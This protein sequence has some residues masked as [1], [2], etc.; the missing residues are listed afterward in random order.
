MPVGVLGVTV[1]PVFV[2]RPPAAP[3]DTPVEPVGPTPPEHAVVVDVDPRLPALVDEPTEPVAPIHGPPTTLEP[4][5]VESVDELEP[6][7]P[8]A[9]PDP[10]GRPVSPV[11]GAVTLDG[12]PVALPPIP[13]VFAVDPPPIEPPPVP[14]PAPA[15]PL[16]PCANAGPAARPTTNA[17]ASNLFNT[18][19]S[20]LLL[21][22]FT[23]VGAR[24]MPEIRACR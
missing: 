18:L 16:T 20:D 10:V 7:P 22:R 2:L 1:V 9:V 15:P 4:V 13:G 11:L 14:T 23:G 5:P 24:A 8:P 3:P 6:T 17:P 12:A 19:M 21:E